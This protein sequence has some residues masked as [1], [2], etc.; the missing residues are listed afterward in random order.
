MARADTGTGQIRREEC[1]GSACGQVAGDGDVDQRWLTSRTRSRSKRG[2]VPDDAPAGA[3]LDG[4][5]GQAVRS[6]C[7]NTEISISHL[8]TGRSSSYP[9][10]RSCAHHLRDHPRRDIPVIMTAKVSRRTLRLPVVL[11]IT[12][13][14]ALISSATHQASASSSPIVPEKLL[15][16]ETPN[17][18]P[19]RQL[20]GPE[21]EAVVMAFDTDEL[22]R[23]N[24]GVPHYDYESHVLTIRTPAASR[25]A[26]LAQEQLIQQIGKG[27][28]RTE[29]VPAS[30]SYSELQELVHKYAGQTFGKMY[31]SSTVVNSKSERALLYV[32]SLDS[33]SL[34]ELADSVESDNTV[35]VT[36]SDGIFQAAGRNN[37]SSAY[38]GGARIDN[39]TSGFSWKYGTTIR[40]LT[41]GHCY[42]QGANRPVNTPVSFLGAVYNTN[43]SNWVSGVGTVALIGG[44]NQVVRGDF[45][46]ATITP[47]QTGAAQIYVGGPGSFSSRIVGG[48]WLGNPTGGDQFCSGGATAGEIC[49]WVLE[50]ANLPRD[51]PYAGGELAKRM[52]VGTRPSAPC[53]MGGDSGGP[54]Y[55]VDGAGKV[56]AKGILSGTGPH[57]AGGCSVIFGSIHDARQLWT[58]TPL[59][60]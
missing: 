5:G 53:A 55:T 25:D 22:E 2:L 56:F 43:G 32:T 38:Y 18:P 12:L 57:G 31:V 20:V 23:L 29:I 51:V 48:Y 58:G 52:W 14:I 3:R 41:A 54:I 26:A 8:S 19:S 45:A 28:V 13:T 6:S 16:I 21:R 24:L 9:G 33:E 50:T 59:T 10:E 44:A 4:G 30:H 11:A 49:G 40:M 60:A 34:R 36:P 42:P 7:H 27:S 1:P 17:A 35:A 15:L 47:S 46:L 39:C 37:D